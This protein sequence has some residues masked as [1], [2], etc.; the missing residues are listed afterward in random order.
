MT[1]KN[2]AVLVTGSNRGLGRALVEASLHAGAR[3]VYAAARDPQ[4]LA[5]LVAGASG[6]VVPLALD[7]TSE[8]SLAAA[9]SQ[10]LD[11]SVLI[12]NA[13]V[14]ASHG[15]LTSSVE[16]LTL[17][18]ATNVFGTLA[19]TKAFLPAL[20]RAAAQGRAAVVN[21]LS[22]VSLANMPALGG[23]SASKAAAASITEALRSDLAKSNI[24]VHG[25]FAGAI[26][27]DM[28]RDLQMPKAR[29]EDVARAI[30]E[31]VENGIDDIFPDTMSQ[32]AFATWRS[33]PKE[34]ARQLASL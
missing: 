17:D 15:V 22:V 18:F 24:S 26:D 11:V 29:P 1:L 34:L 20:Q 10:A 8:T 27:T 32:G 13:G 23:Y 33:D 9:A 4:Q 28:T 31:G 30:I 3:R 2:A 21:V 7:I 19:A 14:V 12:N 5:S 25:V 6:R 16:G